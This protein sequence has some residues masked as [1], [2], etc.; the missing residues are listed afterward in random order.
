M[1]QTTEP[2]SLAHT[3]KS[4]SNPAAF[5]GLGLV[6][7]GFALALIPLMGVIGWPLMIAG[8]VLGIIGAAKKWQPMW[9]N[10][11]NIVLGFAG[12]GLAVVLVSAGLLAGAGSD[13][14]SETQTEPAAE[15]PV[16]V[17]TPDETTPAGEAFIDGVLT[18]DEV[19]IV[20]TDHRI[21]P[22]GEPGNEYGDKPV[23]AFWYETTNLGTA[24]Y[25]IQP[26]I[27]IS[28]F[29]AFQDNDP[30][31]TNP[32]GVGS[33]PDDQFLESQ[34]ATIKPGGSVS[35]AIAYELTDLTTPVE[36]VAGGRFGGDEIG[37]M[38]FNL[39]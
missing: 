3:P 5:V 27:W 7:A 13:S 36:L 25:D 29:E 19:K 17:E 23:I 4:K 34:M 8:L 26:Y 9:A 21:I 18:T 30:N 39:D 28:L 16:E 2:T 20:I 32:L 22:V 38:T 1:T 15:A 6:L 14:Q 10:I 35:N 24:D 33:L 37:R 31:I 12:P 11:V